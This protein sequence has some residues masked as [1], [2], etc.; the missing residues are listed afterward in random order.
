[1]IF[2]RTYPEGAAAWDGA[3]AAALPPLDDRSPDVERP[4]WP[5]GVCRWPVLWA[6]AGPRA[7]PL[8]TMMR[9]WEEEERRRGREKGREAYRAGPRRGMP[10][11]LGEDCGAA[12][13]LRG[14]PALRHAERRASPLSCAICVPEMPSAGAMASGSAPFNTSSASACSERWRSA[15]WMGA[16]VWHDERVVQWAQQSSVCG[17]CVV[18]L[19]VMMRECRRQTARDARWCQSRRRAMHRL[20]TL[21]TA[22]VLQMHVVDT[23]VDGV[24]ERKKEQLKLILNTLQKIL[25]FNITW[26]Q[27]ISFWHHQEQQKQVFDLLNKIY[28]LIFYFSNEKNNK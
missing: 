22:A 25:K 28:F 6:R 8:H 26:Q 18:Y 14:G 12:T 16:P 11:W 10:G 9:E 5:C 23:F 7:G 2:K 21:M 3:P 27:Q 17:E 24:E 13:R 19:R 4:P 20:T 15:S 1:M